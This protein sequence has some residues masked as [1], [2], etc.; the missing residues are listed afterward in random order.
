MRFKWNKIEQ[1][2]YDEIKRIV[3]FKIHTSTS[4]FQLKVVISQKGKPVS[5][6]S[7]KLTY[8]QKRYTVTEK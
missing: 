1:D 5:L 6:Y 7:I 2:Y 4:K 3:E 8:S